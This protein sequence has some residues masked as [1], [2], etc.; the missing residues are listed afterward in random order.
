M[1]APASALIATVKHTLSISLPRGF[2]IDFKRTK[3]AALT[4][5]GHTGRASLLSRK[6]LDVDVGL[7][8]A[9]A[10]LRHAGA[11]Y[12]SDLA[13]AKEKVLWCGWLEPR[14][15]GYLRIARHAIGHAGRLTECT[16][17]LGEALALYV[18]ERLLGYSIQLYLR[19]PEKHPLGMD[20][21]ATVSTGEVALEAKARGRWSKKGAKKEIREQFA[22]RATATEKYGFIL[23]YQQGNSKKRRRSYVQL[24]D[25]PGLPTHPTPEDLLRRI[26]E[27]YYQVSMTIGLWFLAT[28]LAER[29]G[30][31]GPQ[32]PV[33]QDILQRIR[34]NPANHPGNHVIINEV[35]Y[36]GRFFERPNREPESPAEA[37]LL[38]SWPY[39][40]FGIDV[41]VLAI[42][43]QAPDDELAKLLAYSKMLLGGFSFGVRG[44]YGA[45]QYSGLSDGVLRVDLAA[46]EQLTME[47][48][49]GPPNV[50]LHAR[51]TMPE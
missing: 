51:G 7:L 15:D 23:L 12:N 38:D 49:D 31:T 37:A 28:V 8:A 45:I 2:R 5:F 25:P 19:I 4:T 16:A 26:L 17:S 1:N 10:I 14:P 18:A 22:K 42:L 9:T 21:A 24:V 20:F 3:C 50:P 13:I 6:P 46:K 11:P 29:L 34:M 47:E 43:I 48:L 32:F 39:F 41:R 33:Q 36:V 35:K 44:E 40:F 30:V 27:H